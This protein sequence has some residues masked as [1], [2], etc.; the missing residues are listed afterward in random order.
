MTYAVAF[1]EEAAFDGGFIIMAALNPGIWVRYDDV[2]EAISRPV[3]LI[4][5]GAGV[6]VGIVEVY[7]E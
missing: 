7:S 4:A 6:F 2:G 3:N 1:G 5:S